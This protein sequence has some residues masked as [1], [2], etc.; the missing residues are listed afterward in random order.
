MMELNL[1]AGFVN[2]A[3]LTSPQQVANAVF[4]GAAAIIANTV[5]AAANSTVLGLYTG[6]AGTVP[7]MGGVTVYVA[8]DE[9]PVT[10]TGFSFGEVANS[11]VVGLP[12]Q[13]VWFVTNGNQTFQPSSTFMPLPGSLTPAANTCT[14]WQC[15]AGTW[16][17]TH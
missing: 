4:T 14:L 7:Q 15:V 8:S 11:P 2:P 12:F 9:A 5:A 13:R 17:Q 1:G 16:A 10:V 3:T 6:P